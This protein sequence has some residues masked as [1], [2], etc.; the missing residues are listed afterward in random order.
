MS[1]ANGELPT[2]ERVRSATFTP[3]RLGRR[4][5]D[6]TEVR[7]FCE[8]VSDGL[9]RLINDNG[10]PIAGSWPRTPACAATRSCARRRC[11]PA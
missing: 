8:W 7:A 3:A 9:G 11:A 6:E 5:L 4:G 10:R 2:P 1:H